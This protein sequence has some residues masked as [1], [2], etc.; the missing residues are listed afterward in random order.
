MVVVERF[1]TGSEFSIS[2]HTPFLSNFKFFDL[3][4]FRCGVFFRKVATPFRFV[5]AR[6]LM[7]IATVSIVI[8]IIMTSLTL[9]NYN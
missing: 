6:P 7:I 1:F 3:M 2:L 5:A 8:T 9:V 4:A